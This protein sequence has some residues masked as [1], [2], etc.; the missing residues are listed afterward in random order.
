[1]EVE[2]IAVMS[3]WNVDSGVF[4]HACP[5]VRAWRDMGY[6]VVVL[7][8]IRE[9]FHG[10]VM[11]GPDEPFVIRCFGTSAKTNFLD[12][13]PLLT[14]DYDVLVVEDLKMLPMSKLALIWHHVREKAKVLV[15]VLH[16]NTI[17]GAR[18]PQPPE[19][20]SL[21]WDAVVYMDER[22]GWFARAIYGDR[23]RYIPWP[24]MPRREGDKAEA[25]RA[26]GLPEGKPIVLCYARGGYE[27]YLPE[28]P[29]GALEDALF[30]VLTGRD[31]DWPD[32][33]QVE[34]RKTGPLRNEELDLYAFASDAIVLHKARTPAIP[35]ALKSTAL[36]YFIGTMRPILVPRIGEPF[37]IHGREVLKYSDRA[38]LRD[39]LLD[40][41]GKGPRSREALA[42][43]EEVLREHDPEKVAKMFLE[44]FEELASGGR[45]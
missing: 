26:L 42:S 6:D 19:F 7:S 16:E 14:L 8:F 13:R 4:F 39:L 12:P 43:A 25:R 37:S 1:V 35:L 40:A 34:V 9:D 31:F 36:Y 38:E 32:Y 20:Y 21:A 23:A 2:R 29:D 18:P 3:A 45:A 15:H 41:L 10:T 22:Q 28:L 44:L 11:F 17:Y 24:C 33:P 5:L 27:P 30:L